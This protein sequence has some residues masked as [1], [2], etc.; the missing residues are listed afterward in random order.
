MANAYS[1]IATEIADLNPTQ[2][3][4]EIQL[5][6]QEELIWPRLIRWEPFNGPGLIWQ[7]AQ[8][9]ALTMYAVSE[10]QSTGYTETSGTDAQA[11]DM[12]NRQITA[13]VKACDVLLTLSALTA[14]VGDLQ[15]VV[16]DSQKK[17]YFDL[18]STDICGKYTEATAAH[19]IGT[20][21]TQLS[22]DT[23]L[24]GFE[25]L[26]AQAAMGK[27]WWVIGPAQIGE[28]M[29]ID[30]FA[31]FLNYGRAVLDQDIPLEAGSMGVGPLGV[32]IFWDNNIVESSGL[33]SI[34]GTS[35]ALAYVEKMPFRVEVDATTLYVGN[36]SIR[37]GGTAF[38]GVGG[39]RDTSTTNK[40]LVDIIS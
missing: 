27:K 37:I 33:H 10:S 20:D 16:R 18:V 5:A 26:A 9:P 14:S 15:G 12:S 4:T 34:M 13:G 19:E 40:F 31:K 17:A 11:F 6:A 7:M 28:V 38:Y 30:E 21:G 32:E 3:A 35:E 23:F 39:L 36:R 24:A 2:I 1:T 29:K 8:A 22:Y 25:L